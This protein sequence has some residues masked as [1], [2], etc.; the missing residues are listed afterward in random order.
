VTPG[1]PEFYRIATSPD[2][3]ACPLLDR[4]EV[5]VSGNAAISHGVILDSKLKRWGKYLIS[6]NH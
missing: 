1:L 5:W 2:K 3:N 6:K 4:I